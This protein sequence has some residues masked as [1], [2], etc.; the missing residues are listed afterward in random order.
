MNLIRRNVAAVLAISAL[1]VSGLS[2]AVFEAAHSTAVARHGAPNATLIEAGVS[3]PGTDA[4]L[5]EA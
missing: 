3:N 4:T 5:I 2:L 1:A